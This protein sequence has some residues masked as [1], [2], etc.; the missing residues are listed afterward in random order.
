M[1]RLNNTQQ[2]GADEI[3]LWGAGEGGGTTR[4]IWND[5]L[6]K[7]GFSSALLMQRGVNEIHNRSLIYPTFYV[8]GMFPADFRG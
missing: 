1:G 6:L 7:P 4:V 5:D 2:D 3:S 8:L